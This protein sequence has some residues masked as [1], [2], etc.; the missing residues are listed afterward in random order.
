MFSYQSLDALGELNRLE[1]LLF[2]RQLEESRVLFGMLEIPLN[3]GLSSV[4]HEGVFFG[5]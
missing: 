4:V 5:G 2:S 3:M 1:T